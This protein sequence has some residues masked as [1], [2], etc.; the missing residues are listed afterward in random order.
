MS[1]R[2]LIDHF[3]CTQNVANFGLT[4]ELSG[5]AGFFRFGK[6]AI[7]YGQSASG[8]RSTHPTEPLYD[9]IRDVK[10]SGSTIKLP[11]DPAQVIDNLRLERYASSAIHNESKRN[12]MKVVRGAYYALRPL[13]PVGIRRHVQK[14]YL[15]AWHRKPFPRWPVDRSVEEILEK[16]LMISMK[17]QGIDEVPFIWFWPEGAPGCVL[18][19]HDVETPSGRDFCSH[20][21]DLDDEFGVKASFQIVPEKR[22]TVSEKF[23]RNFHERGFEVGIQDLNHDGYLYSDKDEFFRRAKLINQYGKEYGARGFRAALLFRNPSWSSALDFSYEM[24]VPNVAHLDPQQGGCCTVFP[25]FI[26]N[27]LELPVTTTQDYSLFHILQRHCLT[28]WNTQVRLILEKHG[29][30]SFVIHPDYII[31]EKNQRTYR[32]LLGYLSRLRTEEK[33]WITLP[34]EVDRWWRARSQMTLVSEV[35]KWSI[36]GPDKERARIAY[37]R[38]ENDRLAYRLENR[39]GS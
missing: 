34:R 26:G 28:L 4:G 37:A 20:L 35:G 19:T 31:K 2:V 25:Y 27:L 13:M 9:V 38:I 39:A 24:S 6:D 33:V 29:L 8:F 7:C 15:R 5:D 17:A 18:I 16:L 36:D 23:L 12:V 32:D 1:S 11:F 30:I 22:Y 14:L 21:M 10:V 3:R